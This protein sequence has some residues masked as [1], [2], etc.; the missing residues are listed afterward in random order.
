[1]QQQQAQLEETPPAA[2]PEQAKS[3]AE[4]VAELVRKDESVRARGREAAERINAELRQAEETA[5]ALASQRK[6]G[7]RLQAEI[8]K[9][10]A[11]KRI[12]AQEGAALQGQIAAANDAL[13]SVLTLIA[14]ET[15]GAFVELV[16]GRMSC[17]LL[18]DGERFAYK[19][20][21]EKFKRRSIAPF[22]VMV[23]LSFVFTHS[24]PL[25][26][27]LQMWSMFYFASLAL[28][29]NILLANGS[30]IRRWW[31][32]HHY[33][34]AILSFILLV[35]PASTETYQSFRPIFLSYTIGQR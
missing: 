24:A 19:N 2:A 33:L 14:P 25:K 20:D 34:S 22:L 11:A 10:V 12:S 18:H 35:W 28:R 16:L 23:L 27:L 9:A 32:I 29:E 26:C 13:K 17:K 7:A 8:A 21:Y 30:H 1:M 31:I 5:A 4:R 15:G 6:E 3:L